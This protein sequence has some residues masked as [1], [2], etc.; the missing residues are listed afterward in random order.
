MS[1]V[2]ILHHEDMIDF[3]EHHHNKKNNKYNKNFICFPEYVKKVTYQKISSLSNV[4]STNIF[5]KIYNIDEMTNANQQLNGEKLFLFCKSNHDNQLTKQFVLKAMDILYTRSLRIKSEIKIVIKQNQ[6][7]I[8]MGYFHNHFILDFSLVE[9][10]LLSYMKKEIMSK[11]N[12]ICKYIPFDH[13]TFSNIPF[14]NTCYNTLIQKNIKKIAFRSEE[15]LGDVFYIINKKKQDYVNE[16]IHI[17]DGYYGLY[18]DMFHP[19]PT[20]YSCC[21]EYN[22]DKKMLFLLEQQK[23]TNIEKLTSLKMYIYKDHVVLYKDYLPQC[24]T[25]YVLID[26]CI[27]NKSQICKQSKFNDKQKGNMYQLQS[28]FPNLSFIF[29]GKKWVYHIIDKNAT[30]DIPE[31]DEDYSYDDMNGIT[32]P[33]YDLDGDMK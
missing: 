9:S 14:D 20:L 2:K 10:S 17:A 31:Y 22:M 21:D 1:Y 11:I 8:M 25:F 24:L 13:F 26:S 27:H 4:S 28:T 16:I 15:D 32:P 12:I 30:I 3:H 5:V 6:N 19:K 29:I 23:K 7:R 18:D 33:E